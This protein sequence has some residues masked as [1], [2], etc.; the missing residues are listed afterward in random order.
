M[1]MIFSCAAF[2]PPFLRPAP[3]RRPPFIWKKTDCFS[4]SSYFLA[5]H[6]SF[7]K[8]FGP[9]VTLF[10]VP[11][12]TIRLSSYNPTHSNSESAANLDCSSH[13]RLRLML[14]SAAH[15]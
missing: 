9:P 8:G 12:R 3:G 14:E 10:L 15:G 4:V 11:W 5:V 7:V 1:S 13:C 6:L 2:R